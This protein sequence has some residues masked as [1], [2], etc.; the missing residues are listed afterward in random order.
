MDTGLLN[1]FWYTDVFSNMKV[2][3]STI[4]MQINKYVSVSLSGSTLNRLNVG[5]KYHSGSISRGVAK[6]DDLSPILVGSPSTSP[7]IVDAA[8]AITKGK[9]YKISFGYAGSPQQLWFVPLV[10][11]WHITVLLGLGN[12]TTT[13]DTAI[14][15]A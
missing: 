4:G 12:F 7:S 14:S 5:Q 1:G 13:V 9:V 2:R 6:G 10:S 11:F 8:P 3:I 15:L